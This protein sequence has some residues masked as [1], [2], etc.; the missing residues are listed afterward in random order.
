MST[1]EIVAKTPVQQDAKTR[2]EQLAALLRS[3]NCRAHLTGGEDRASLHVVNTAVPSLTERIT[4]EEGPHGWRFKWSWREVIG[5][6]DNMPA[7]A[8]QIAKVL[9]A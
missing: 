3:R 2:L 5:P 7:I 6:A 4:C 9:A 1:G 8:D